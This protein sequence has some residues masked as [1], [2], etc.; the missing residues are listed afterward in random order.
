MTTGFEAY[1]VTV[2]PTKGTHTYNLNETLK[3]VRVQTGLKTA[4][5]HL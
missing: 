5:F 1:L 2:Y 4:M 3:H